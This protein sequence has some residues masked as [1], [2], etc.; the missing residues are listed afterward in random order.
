[1]RCLTGHSESAVSPFNFASFALK[2]SR[3]I[4]SPAMQAFPSRSTLNSKLSFA[5]GVEYQCQ[6]SKPHFEKPGSKLSC[7]SA[8]RLLRMLVF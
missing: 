6:C 3:P 8:L 1:M 7:C 4:F 5:L 2:L